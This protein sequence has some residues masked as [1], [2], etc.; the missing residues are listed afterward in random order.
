MA[1]PMYFA[2]QQQQI[3][4]VMREWERDRAGINARKYSLFR[5]FE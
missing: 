3:M 4:A 5:D 1:F 2:Q